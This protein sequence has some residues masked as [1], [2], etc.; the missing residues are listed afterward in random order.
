M[1]EI[2]AGELFEF[3]GGPMPEIQR[4]GRA[5]LERV[6]ASGNVI[7][8]QLGAPANEVLHGN[9]FEGGEFFGIRLELGEEGGVADT[10]DLHG[11]NVTAAFIVRLEGIEEFEIVDDGMGRGEGAD[12]IL[13]AEGVD[14]VFDADAR[15]RLGEGGGGDA[16]EA[17]AAMGGG[18]G[19]AGDIEQR[20]AADGNEVGVAVN[21]VPVQVGLY[22]VDEDRRIFGVLAAADEERR[23]DELEAGGAHA[24]IDVNALFEFGLG[25]REGVIE[26]DEDLSRGGIGEGV[27]Q[28]RIIRGEDVFGEEDA[29][30]PTDLDG[31]FN[32]GH[33]FNLKRA[34]GFDENYLDSTGMRMQ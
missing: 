34:R 27:S 18:G 28:N 13:F 30:L 22:F 4:A 31:A 20:T 1:G 21:V 8:M 9:R 19:E 24:E 29:Q 15:I 14:A 12:E 25:L 7:Q 17:H 3:V 26:E 2:E 5:H 10:G 33:S 6:A 32:D 11:L 23:P 16:D